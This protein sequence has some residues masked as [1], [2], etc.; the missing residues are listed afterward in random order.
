MQP[1][2]ETAW[3]KAQRAADERERKAMATMPRQQRR[4]RA[5]KGERKSDYNFRA[6]ERWPGAKHEREIARRLRQQARR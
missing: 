4:F 5:R 1:P 2:H 3:Q 6:A